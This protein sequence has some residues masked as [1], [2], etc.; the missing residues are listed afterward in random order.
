MR[1]SLVGEC[2]SEVMV[3][4]PLEVTGLSRFG[5]SGSKPWSRQ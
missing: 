5:L 2:A 4:L 3:V 1:V